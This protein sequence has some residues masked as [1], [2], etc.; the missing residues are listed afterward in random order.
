MAATLSGS[1]AKIQEI[2]EVNVKVCLID[3]SFMKYG[4]KATISVLCETLIKRIYEIKQKGF[5][6]NLL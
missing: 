2:C 1:S 6:R 4:S 3:V 5:S